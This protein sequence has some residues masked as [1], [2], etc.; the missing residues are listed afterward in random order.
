MNR[1]S[2]VAVAGLECSKSSEYAKSKNPKSRDYCTWFVNPWASIVP[3]D[4]A[5]YSSVSI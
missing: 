5:L 2:S 1:P 3:G 4:I